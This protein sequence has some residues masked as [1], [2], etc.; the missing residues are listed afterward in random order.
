MWAKHFWYHSSQCTPPCHWGLC[1]HFETT[2]FSFEILRKTKDPDCPK[3]HGKQSEASTSRDGSSFGNIRV[4]P[5][6][7]HRNPPQVWGKEP[8]PPTSVKSNL[9]HKHQW[10]SSRLLIF[11]AE[12]NYSFPLCLQ[13]GGQQAEENECFKQGTIMECTIIRN[14]TFVNLM[15]LQVIIIIVLINCFFSNRRCGPRLAWRSQGC[16]I[17]QF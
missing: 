2:K 17:L 10:S 3:R 9:V 13:C 4:K 14:W 5:T 12:R 6:G 7:K 1:V 16:I 15:I 11:N 8:K